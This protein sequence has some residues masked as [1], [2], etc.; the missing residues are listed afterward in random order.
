M[1]IYRWEWVAGGINYLMTFWFYPALIIIFSSRSLTKLFDH[2]FI[3][4]LGKITYDAYIWHCP[5]FLLLHIIP[6]ITGKSW[7]LLTAKAMLVYTVGSFAVGT[8]SYYVLERP[9]NHGVKKLLEK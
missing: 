8:V 7:D 4:T 1:M 2:R 5:N 6:A 3:G 9:I